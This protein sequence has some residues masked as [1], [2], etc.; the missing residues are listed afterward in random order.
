MDSLFQRPLVYEQKVRQTPGNI[1]FVSFEEI[2]REPIWLPKTFDGGAT[3]KTWVRFLASG[4]GLNC[5]LRIDLTD[6]VTTISGG[7]MV[8][9]FVNTAG[10]IYGPF[11]NAISFAFAIPGYLDVI[12]KGLDVDGSFDAAVQ[13]RILY[14][15][16]DTFL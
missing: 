11:T 2:V 13:A 16:V 15:Y 5:D 4:S 6:G 10:V 8:Q 7:T 12:V 14:G 9:K 1:S 3:L